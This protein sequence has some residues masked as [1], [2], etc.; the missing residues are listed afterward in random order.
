MATKSSKP[1]ATKNAS[2][3]MTENAIVITLS[4]AE[5]RKAAACLRKNGK[6][7]FSVT[8][9]SVTKLPGLLDNGKQ[10]D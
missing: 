6:I 1:K 10:I 7:T 5:Q 4:A 8:E 3:V 2:I 9:H